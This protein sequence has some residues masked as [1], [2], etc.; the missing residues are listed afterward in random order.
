MRKVK[1]KDFIPAEYT[2]LDE[3]TE[4]GIKGSKRLVKGTNQYQKEFDTFGY[5]HKWGVAPEYREDGYVSFN[6]AL[7]E[8]QDGTMREVRVDKVKFIDN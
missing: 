3:D 1:F 4:W 7:I 5:F 6:V 8:T 2:I